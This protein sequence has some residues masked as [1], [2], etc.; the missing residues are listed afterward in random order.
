[1]HI[2]STKWKVELGSHK[3]FFKLINDHLPTKFIDIQEMT[4]AKIK[5]LKETDR[6]QLL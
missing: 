3:D 5:Q 6:D 1:M 2:D 4:L